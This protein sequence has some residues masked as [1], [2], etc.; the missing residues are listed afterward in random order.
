M[1][2]VSLCED[3]HTST[4]AGETVPPASLFSY[5]LV[6]RISL[7]MLNWGHVRPPSSVCVHSKL[8]AP[9]IT[10]RTWR[11][12]QATACFADSDKGTGAKMNLSLGLLLTVTLRPPLSPI[13]TGNLLLKAKTHRRI[14]NSIQHKQ[15]L[16]LLWHWVPLVQFNLWNLLLVEG[17]NE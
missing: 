4:K 10:P 3:T 8:M 11:K 15:D 16:R 12:H 9:V 6:M 17:K 2:T 7:V 1:H 5:N 13:T 14:P